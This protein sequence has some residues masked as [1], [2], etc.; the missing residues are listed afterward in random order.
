MRARVTIVLILFLAMS[1]WSQTS[2]KGFDLEN[3]TIPIE[4]IKDGGPPKDG[5]PAIA[6]ATFLPISQ[7]T[8]LKAGDLVMS[9]SYAG[10]TR[11]YPIRIFNHHEIVND[12]IEDL[13]FSVTY[14]PLCGTG[15]V[16]DRTIEGEITSFGVSGLLYQ[17]DVLLY[18]RATESLW[19]QLMLKSIS[20]ERVGH[21][22][23]WLPSEF[24]TWSSW[25][26]RY[27]DG[28]VISDKTGYRRNYKRTPYKG[29]ETSDD[30]YF[31]VPFYRKDLGIKD[32]ILGVEIN[33][34]STA[35]DLRLFESGRVYG[36]A[37]GGQSIKIQ[38]D[39]QSR[40]A[41][42]TDAKSGEAVS[43]VFA[44]WFAWQAFHPDTR[45]LSSKEAVE[46]KDDL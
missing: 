15:M 40:Y 22:L 16:F 24:M 25:K 5:I 32:W 13:A 3:A 9:V 35:Y 31:P 19:S 6:E 12:Q 43:H 39:P 33:G 45:L 7:A 29:Y 2:K 36:D 1:A 10:T 23:R 20:G 28:E 38:Y 26:E 4:D 42:V 21:S 17:S 46:R 44:F 18:D 8:Y 34:E 27:P 14:C 11:A 37:V 41:S 30:V